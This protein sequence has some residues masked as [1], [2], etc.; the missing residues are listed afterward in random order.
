MIYKYEPYFLDTINTRDMVQATSVSALYHLIEILLYR[1]NS[2]QS[3]QCMLY[4][5]YDRNNGAG[6]GVVAF[7]LIC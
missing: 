1:K 6:E 3:T 2:D 7:P 5:K 4:C